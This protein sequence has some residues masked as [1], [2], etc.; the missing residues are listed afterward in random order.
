MQDI[1]FVS[2]G[3][4]WQISTNR[5]YGNLLPSSM[6][7][8]RTRG[9]EEGQRR[10]GV[11]ESPAHLNHLTRHSHGATKTCI[12]SAKPPVN[13]RRDMLRN[14]VGAAVCI[15]RTV[16]RKWGIRRATATG[17][18]AAATED[19][20]SSGEKGW[21]RRTYERHIAAPAA[22]SQDTPLAIWLPPSS[23][24]PR[25]LL[26][27]QL[28]LILLLLTPHAHPREA[29]PWWFGDQVTDYALRIPAWPGCSG[30]TIRRSWSRRGTRTS[31]HGVAGIAS[32]QTSKH[33]LRS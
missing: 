14:C 6:V 21:V 3:C 9:G 4:C 31:G 15:R 5:L 27:L 22:G 26:L 12:N 1:R 17:A 28:V 20:H 24:L 23:R 7:G 19:S 2:S 11:Q 18:S 13:V 32:R 8:G 10:V 16:T 30:I 25:S 29:K 33:H